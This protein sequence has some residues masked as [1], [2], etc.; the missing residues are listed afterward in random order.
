VDLLAL[1]QTKKISIIIVMTAACI[2]S[3]YAML[4]LVNI[5]FMDVLVFITGLA[6][7]SRIGMTVGF[8]SWAIYGVINPYGFVLPI[9]VATAT[10]ESVYGLVGGLLGRQ[11]RL[12]IHSNPIVASAQ[13]TIVGF[14]ITFGYDVVTNI[15]FAVTFGI[16]L[17]ITLIE[18]IPFA[19]VHAFSN[20]NIFFVGVLP[21]IKGIRR[22]I[23]ELNEND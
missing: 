14:I 12:M 9:L 13:Y 3:N 6:F 21:A 5:S 16:P 10:M 2:G 11:N 17:N 20:V 22:L 1:N 8:L 4:G 15:V 23:P 19:I 7:G 18:G